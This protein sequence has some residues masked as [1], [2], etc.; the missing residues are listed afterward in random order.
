MSQTDF[1]HI[2]SDMLSLIP[3]ALDKREGSIIYNA[4]A[5]AAASLATA[6]I[7]LE[8]TLRRCFADTATGDDLQRRCAERG[9]HRI[10][11]TSAVCKGEFTDIYGKAMAIPLGTRFRVNS[12]TYVADTAFDDGS[13]RMVC[14]QKGT[15]GNIASAQLTPID[16]IP[17]LARARITSLLV[18]A[19]NA[20]SDD[21]LRERYFASFDSFSFGGNISDYV[22]RISAIDG[23]GAVKVFPAWNGGGTVKAVCLAS[24]LSIPDDTLISTIQELCD[25][26]DSQGTG[27]GFAP[28]GHTV[29]I[30]AASEFPLNIAIAATMQSGYDVNTLTP[31][32]KSAAEQ[33]ILKLRQDWSSDEQTVVRVSQ[34]EHALLSVDGVLDISATINSSSSNSLLDAH[35]V[36]FLSDFTVS[37]GG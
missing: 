18:S 23:V 9:I 24:D 37:E 13:Y 11:A 29:T 28:I 20:E 35:Q 30:A 15:D 32:L 22:Q 26:A 34:L 6:Y 25:P 1:E 12:L 7:N 2:L 36:P 8:L 27:R 19:R 10:P 33:Y 31:L 16:D 14:E 21:A 4:L 17:S 5:P 3:D